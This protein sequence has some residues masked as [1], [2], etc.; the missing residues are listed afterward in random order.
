MPL[1]KCTWRQNCLSILAGSTS[2]RDP[3]IDRISALISENEDNIIICSRE[4]KPPTKKNNDP[5]G[6][7][8][9][10]EYGGGKYYFHIAPLNRLLGAYP[11]RFLNNLRDQHVLQGETGKLA[12]RPPKSLGQKGRMYCITLCKEQLM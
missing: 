5:L 9:P 12:S 4:G 6:F 3:N 2:R 7:C 8:V 10:D 11:K 1:Q